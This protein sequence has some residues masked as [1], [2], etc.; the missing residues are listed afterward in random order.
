MKL[1]QR[2][3]YCLTLNYLSKLYLRKA[4]IHGHIILVV[5]HHSHYLNVN[6]GSI[7]NN[8]NSFYFVIHFLYIFVF[9]YLLISNDAYNHH[10]FLKS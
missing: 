10:E 4:G 5:K 3:T 2:S 1:V 8:C 6:C 7:L 9:I